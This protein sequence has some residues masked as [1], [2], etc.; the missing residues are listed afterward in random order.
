MSQRK[1]IAVM[2][3]VGLQ[4]LALVF[5]LV[6]MVM[7]DHALKLAGAIAIFVISVAA[8]ILSISEVKNRKQ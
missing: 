3:I 1:I 2:V 7:E 4:F 8:S 5:F 6:A